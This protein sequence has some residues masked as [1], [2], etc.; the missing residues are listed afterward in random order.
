M[1]LYGS[2]M[3]DCIILKQDAKLDAKLTKVYIYVYILIKREVWD[4]GL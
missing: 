3:F 2:G 4:V 1:N